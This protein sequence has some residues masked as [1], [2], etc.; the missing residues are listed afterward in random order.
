MFAVRN[1][2]LSR[3]G[4]VLDLTGNRFLSRLA[5][6]H[7][8][9]LTWLD[10]LTVATAFEFVYYNVDVNLACVVRVFW[11]FRASGG[12]KH[13]V[14]IYS[15]RFFRAVNDSLHY[16]VMFWEVIFVLCSL[17]MIAVEVGHVR[18]RGCVYFLSVATYLD[19][20]ACLLS[21]AVVILY[22]I[23]NKEV[24]T[25][26]RMFKRKQELLGHFLYVTS[27]DYG[28][29]VTYGL[30]LS[31]VTLKFLH[32]LRFNPVIWRL[33]QVLKLAA[34]KLVYVL[35]IITFN[36]F[37][38]GWIMLLLA[39]Y[40]LE[41]FSSMQECMA[42]LFR[43][44]M[45]ELYVKETKELNFFWGPTFYLLFLLAITLLAVNLLI[46]VIC[47]ALIYSYLRPLPNK[48]AELLWLLVHKTVQ[49]C[50]LKVR[51]KKNFA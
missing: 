3:N 6:R 50:G 20:A 45:G 29:A 49:Y 44:V 15:M 33:M 28:L 4:Y 8:S 26:M 42:T 37:V 41:S 47:E 17:Y 16:F 35:A 9:A 51:T 18:E 31:L 43:S 1:E 22:I 23:F 46:S 11:E 13:A 10:H 14:E 30:L 27:I 38:F 21:I 40:K 24:F 32:L 12:A 48:D 25:L 5:I 36:F 19:I 7:L 34:P 39:G 2:K